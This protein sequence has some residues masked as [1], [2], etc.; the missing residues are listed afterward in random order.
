[1]MDT[2]YDS[3]ELF[4]G[5]NRETQEILVWHEDSINPTKIIPGNFSNPFSLFVT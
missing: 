1:M 4:F 5:D 2:V 3:Y